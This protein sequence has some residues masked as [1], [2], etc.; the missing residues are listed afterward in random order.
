VK[1]VIRKV[2]SDWFLACGTGR[3]KGKKLIE[4]TTVAKA[5]RFDDFGSA[6]NRAQQLGLDAQ[7][8]MVEAVP[9]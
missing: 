4:W 8:I 2:G 5:T 6:A 3:G 9:Q 7:T 1:F